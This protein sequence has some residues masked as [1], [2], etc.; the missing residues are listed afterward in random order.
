MVNVETVRYIVQYC[1]VVSSNPNPNP[2]PVVP[3]TRLSRSLGPKVASLLWWQ[4]NV[5]WQGMVAWLKSIIAIQLRAVSGQAS[6]CVIAADRVKEC[7]RSQWSNRVVPGQKLKV[8]LCNEIC[9]VIVE[10]CHYLSRYYYATATVTVRALD[11][12]SGT[13]RECQFRELIL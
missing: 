13:T 12:A 3:E 1:V 4:G 2:L 9:P 8:K 11:S 10:G 6:C 5:E 7:M